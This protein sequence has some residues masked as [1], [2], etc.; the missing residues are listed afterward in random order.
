M[1]SFLVCPPICKAESRHWFQKKPSSLSSLFWGRNCQ[2]LSLNIP[3]VQPT[4]NSG[5]HVLCLKE[6]ESSNNFT[7][8]PAHASGRHNHR[9]SVLLDSPP[10]S[11]FFS[12][13][14]HTYQREN[15]YQGRGRGG[16]VVQDFLLF[17]LPLLFVIV[18]V[19][20]VWPFF[21]ARN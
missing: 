9:I 10:L 7:V 19:G 2:P 15:H 16:G 20:F 4:L 17:V 11:Y 5:V 1:M 18:V 14:C 6:E 13:R 3:S 12:S 8:L 21:L